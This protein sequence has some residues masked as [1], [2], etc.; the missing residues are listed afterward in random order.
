[1]AKTKPRPRLRMFYIT[2]AMA[3]LGIA[4]A[5]V[6]ET[7]L[8]NFL[9]PP[10]GANPFSGLIRDAAGNLYGTAAAGGAQNAGDVY[11]LETTGQ[12][13]VLYSFTGGSDGSG[14][15]SGLIADSAGNLYGTTVYGGT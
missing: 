11:K 4:P 6:T 5:Q 15:R 13:A 14:P 8:H 3:T 10:K 9:S 2:C 7:V 1:M 12:L